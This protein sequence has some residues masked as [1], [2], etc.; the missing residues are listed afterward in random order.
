[1]YQIKWQFDD[2]HFLI[3]SFSLLCSIGVNWI[4]TFSSDFNRNILIG[5][6]A[7]ISRILMNYMHL[8]LK[9][10]RER[11]VNPV[12]MTE[13]TMKLPSIASQWN[14]TINKT[15]KIVQTKDQ[16]LTRSHA[17]LTS[18]IHSIFRLERDGNIQKNLH[19]KFF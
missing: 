2:C 13:P 16:M 12:E 6:N 11:K 3:I 5:T 9:I 8:P 4:A 7:R 10:S 14:Y 18:I 1:M 15:N 17:F 19:K